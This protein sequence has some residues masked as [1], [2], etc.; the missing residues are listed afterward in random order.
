VR[1]DLST[2]AVYLSITA[3]IMAVVNSFWPGW[4][5]Q[6]LRSAR[7]WRRALEYERGKAPEALADPGPVGYWWAQKNGDEESTVVKIDEVGEVS[8]AGVGMAWPLE[9][10]SNDYKLL[11]KVR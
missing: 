7:I 5:G 3:I 11:R 1:I 6:W 4:L 10:F 8:F 9:E 2:P